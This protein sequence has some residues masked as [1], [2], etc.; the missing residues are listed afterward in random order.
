[1]KTGIWSRIFRDHIVWNWQWLP[2]PV[3]LPGELPD[4]GVWWAAVHVVVKPHTAERHISV[5]KPNIRVNRKNYE[6]IE[7]KKLATDQPVDHQ[8]N[9]RRIKMPREK[10]K[11]YDIPKWW[12]AAKMV[13]REKFIATQAYFK[14]Q[15]KSPQS[16]IYT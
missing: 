10:W 15:E 12:V 13:Q 1:M 8:Q 2:T 16:Q 7:I 14:E 5:Q 11:K 4:R 9:Q 6:T 3:F